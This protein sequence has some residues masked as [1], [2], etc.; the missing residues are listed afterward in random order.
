[1]AIKM[2]TNAPIAGIVTDPLSQD[3]LSWFVAQG[4]EELNN[5]GGRVFL[6]TNNLEPAVE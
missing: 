6:R 5:T 3:S 4:F 2:N 1:M